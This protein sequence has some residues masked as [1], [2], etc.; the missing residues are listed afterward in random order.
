MLAVNLLV[1]LK[2]GRVDNLESDELGLFFMLRAGYN[3]KE[4]I[5]AIKIIREVTESKRVSEFKR[6]HPDQ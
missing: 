1:V 2:N 3:S 5:D 4:M 6:S